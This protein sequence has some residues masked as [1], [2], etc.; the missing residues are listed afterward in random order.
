MSF[1]VFLFISLLF[2]G[3]CF[4][5][6]CFND[7]IPFAVSDLKFESLDV[8]KAEDLVG[9]VC[10][11]GLFRLVFFEKNN[12]AMSSLCV[13][14]RNLVPDVACLLCVT[15]NRKAPRNCN[16]CASRRRWLA[17]APF[18]RSAS[19]HRLSPASCRRRRAAPHRGVWLRAVCRR[20]CRTLLRRLA[21][22]SSSSS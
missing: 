18:S 17:R 8:Q 7:E 19:W 20:L 5:H 9:C 4:A 12:I 13:S 2:G 11:V 21:R 10:Y 6:E 3:S 1:F 14:R 15:A 16:A 22:C